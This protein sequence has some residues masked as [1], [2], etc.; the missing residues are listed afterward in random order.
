MTLKLMLSRRNRFWHPHSVTPLSTPHLHLEIAN[1]LK[2]HR[3]KAELLLLPCYLFLPTLLLPTPA[4][5][6]TAPQWRSPHPALSSQTQS[7]PLSGLH[8]PGCSFSA[9]SWLFPS[10]QTHMRDSLCSHLRAW[11]RWT[12]GPLA[13][14]GPA[15]RLH[16]SHHQQQHI[17]RQ[18]TVSQRRARPVH[19]PLSGARVT[20]HASPCKVL[21]VTRLS[22]PSLNNSICLR[23]TRW[24]EVISIN[25][26]FRYW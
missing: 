13:G 20:L 14:A 6:V 24:P 18:S 12:R 22:L 16:L 2:S 3:S 4:D 17:P 9:F 21:Y 23:V 1:H 25:A 11:L 7:H 5:V 26:G 10:P 8:Y 19:Q 15:A